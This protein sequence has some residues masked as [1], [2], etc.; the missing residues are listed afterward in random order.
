MGSINLSRKKIEI[1]ESE[2]E[3]SP[4]QIEKNRPPTFDASKIKSFIFR[5]QTQAKKVSPKLVKYIE[6]LGGA[7]AKS[8]NKQVTHYIYEDLQKNTK[9]VQKAK[10]RS[11]SGD[12]CLMKGTDL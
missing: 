3:N 9:D 11:K 4:M 8:F 12:V 1:I 10:E 5:L 2:E 6:K 7:I